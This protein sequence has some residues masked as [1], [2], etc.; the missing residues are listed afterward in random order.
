[1]RK[2]VKPTKSSGT[3]T[4]KFG[5]DANPLLARWTKS[6]GLPP[7][8][9][10]QTRH[11]KPALQA[12]LREHLGEIKKIAADPAKPTFANTIVALE[13]SGRA[14]NRAASVFFNLE[15]TDSTPELQ[16]L[17]REMAPRFAAH[18]TQILLDQKLF[19]RV[20]DLYQRR[21]TL[22]LT[23]E[24]LRVLER[25]HLA[26][27]RAGA[28]LSSASKARVKIINARLATLVTQ[29]MQ[30]VLKDEQSWRMILDEAGLSGLTPSARSSAAQAAA[31]EGLDGKFV[32]TLARASVEGF[33]TS[34]SRR[35]LRE[36][37]FK[38][39]IA[40]G[41]ATAETDNRAIMA[42]A[43]EL[44]TEYAKLMGFSS[45]AEYSL[46]DTMAKSPANVS[47]LLAEVW[48]KAVARARQECAS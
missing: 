3:V 4:P 26:F 11:F 10:I 24:E 12:G 37:A 43:V 29:F 41:A 8:E 9:K 34:S 6:F 22:K 44:R 45:F 21:D 25:R 46:Q 42:E 39:W 14:I 2:A 35:D 17:S 40:R 30:N 27:T 48:P 1:M 5:A 13:K 38:A 15:A 7:F 32:I 28:R 33:L 47:A 16:A 23:D 19:K 36:H 18:E 31:D 20:D